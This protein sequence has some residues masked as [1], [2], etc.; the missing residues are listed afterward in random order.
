[1]VI[2]AALVKLL[3]TILFENVDKDVNGFL[4]IGNGL[5]LSLTLA[6]ADGQARTFS[7]PIIILARIDDDLPHRKLAFD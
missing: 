1:M 6:D 2:E 7:N 5:F 3:A 4:N